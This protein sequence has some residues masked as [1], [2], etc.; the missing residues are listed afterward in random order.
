PV[1]LVAT[2]ARAQAPETPAPPAPPPSAAEPAPAPAPVSTDVT[3]AAPPDAAPGIPPLVVGQWRTRIY[4]FVELDV[5]RD[6]TQAFPDP[7]GMLSTAIPKG[8]NYAGS[9]DSMTATARNSRLGVVVSPPDFASIR[10]TLTMEGDFMGN[11]P[12]GVTESAFLTN[13]A[14]RL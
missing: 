14:F 8:Y 3:P 1:F 13:P 5:V 10:P 4:G 6:T 2:W 7:G 11:Q 9:R 12:S